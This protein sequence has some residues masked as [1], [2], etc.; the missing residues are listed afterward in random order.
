MRVGIIGVGLLPWKVRYPNKTYYELAAEAVRKALDDAGIGKDR[1][2]NVVYG[3]ADVYTMA[4]RQACAST[5]IQDYIGM[6][7][8][9]SLTVHGGAATGAL[10]VKT[11]YAEIASGMSEVSL[12]VGTGKGMDLIDPET[13]KRS[14]GFLKSI[15]FDLDT[16]WDQPVEPGATHFAFVVQAHIDKYGGPTEEQM[17]KV[18]VKNH[19]NALDNPLAQSGIKLTVEEVL[20][21]P[22][23]SGPAKFYDSCLY[24][25]G[26]AALVLANEKIAR[27]IGRKVVWIEGVGSSNKR[28]SLPDWDDLGGIPCQYIATQKAYRMARIKDPLNE[29]DV[30]ELHD[31]QTGI[32]I[33]SYEE[34]GLCARGEGGRLIDEGVTE[35]TGRLPVNPSGGMIGCGHVAGP[36]G[37][38]RVGEVAL[39]LRGEAGKRQVKI[40]HGRGLTA[41]IGGPGV[42][43]ACSIVL[44]V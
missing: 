44:G 17:A 36:S 18:S 31:L 3:L 42:S 21:S 41:C 19:G 40:A 2:D 39:Q 43:Q 16:T 14:L 24:S 20:K 11:A 8:K 1:V 5:I 28:S 9:S 22:R 26:A 33:M 10:A 15:T 12:V 4:I 7:G 32:E 35:R 37:I 29:L 34:L 27:E 30:I 6:A 38:S 25:E 13:G 23:M